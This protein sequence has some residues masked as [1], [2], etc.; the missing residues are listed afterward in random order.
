MPI[1]RITTKVK[2]HVNG[3][4]VEPG[5][6]VQVVTQS[7][8]NPVCTNGGQSVADAFMHM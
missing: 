2:K 5:L 6:T 1:F 3:V 4:L 7:F 8:S